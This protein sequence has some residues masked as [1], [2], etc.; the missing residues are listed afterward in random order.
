M[1]EISRSM[2]C[3][4]PAEA[5][6]LNMMHNIHRYFGFTKS[7]PMAVGL[8]AGHSDYSAAVAHLM[9]PNNSD[10]E[11]FVDTPEPETPAA[12]TSGFLYQSWGT[13]I[14]EFQEH[15]Q[16][17]NISKVVLADQ[18]G[19]ILI[20]D[21]IERR[22]VLKSLVSSWI[23][24]VDVGNVRKRFQII[25]ETPE[26]SL[27]I[28]TSPGDRERNWCDLSPPSSATGTLLIVCNPWG[29]IPTNNGF[30]ITEI[31]AHLHCCR[32]TESIHITRSK[33]S[34]YLV[35]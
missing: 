35:S 17:G 18:E 8:G 2:H 28:S 22:S 20:S 19:S 10:R 31:Y 27:I 16:Y 9:N 1:A 33:L 5:I 25:I 11:V 12:M 32:A 23:L 14:L 3:G 6:L 21:E 29:H 13:Q 26:R 34:F 7:N 30:K 15:A 4:F 24:Q